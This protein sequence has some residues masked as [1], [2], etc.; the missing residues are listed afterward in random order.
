MPPIVQTQLLEA[1]KL[2]LPS[3]KTTLLGHAAGRRRVES[4]TAETSGDY[5]AQGP[6]NDR[7]QQSYRR[8][9]IDEG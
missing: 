6:T 1:R 3:V 7:V 9:K 2:V 4:E 8:Q 5:L